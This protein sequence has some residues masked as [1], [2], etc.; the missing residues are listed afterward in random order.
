MIPIGDEMETADLFR[1][2]PPAW[3]F[4]RC[5]TARCV[6]VIHLSDPGRLAEESDE[7][8]VRH[9]KRRAMM[10]AVIRETLRP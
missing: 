9:A 1:A 10:Q 8:I 6:R 7:V 4:W 3:P 5:A 2:P